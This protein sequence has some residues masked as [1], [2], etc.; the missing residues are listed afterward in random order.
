M[1]KRGWLVNDWLTAIPNTRTFWHDLLDWFP[2]LEDKT[3][4]YTDFSVL[5][6]RIESLPTRPDY[7]IR[8][9]TYFRKLNINIPTISLIQDVQENKTQQIDVIN[10]SNVVVFNTFY[11]YEKYKKYINDSIRVSICPLGVDFD[12]FKP[13]SEKNQ[14]VLPNSIL[15]IG[16]STIYPKGFDI[17]LK[18]IKNTNYN[19]C[20]ILKDDT[21]LDKIPLEDRQRVR[22]FNKISTADVRL[23]INS[24]ILCLC[25]SYEETQHLSGIECAACNIPIVA[26]PVGV[27]YDNRDSIEWGCLVN[28]DSKFIETIDF[29]IEHI[30]TFSP[31]KCFIKKYSTDICRH[32]WKCIIANLPITPS[33]NQSRISINMTDFYNII[34]TKLN[35]DIIK[36][37][38]DCGSMD[39]GD[40]KFFK[41]KYPDA[42]VYAIEGLKSNYDKFLASESGIIGINA[43]ISSYD[44]E[45]IFYEKNING[46]H[47]IYDRG[48]E[49][50]NVQYPV[51]CYRF[52]TI[53]K[54]Y[55]IDTID[56][57]KLDVEGASLCALQ[58]LGECLNN[59]KI[60]HIETETYPYFK[61]QKL[62]NECIKF[63]IDNNFVMLDI[64]FC[65]ITNDGYQSDSVWIHKSYF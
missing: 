16:S 10:S 65:K 17:L 47:S 33:N 22:I 44:G 55:S 59:V 50:G 38:V 64:T 25:T 27:Y 24:C 53:L 51:K 36:T 58:S 42:N 46:I 20:L 60:M 43:V 12:F 52:D 23:I 2:N 28:D 21:S 3:N 39:G 18:I 5:A 35:D 4:G 8:N 45:T 62:H 6:D 31:R 48:Q 26:R 15:F 32:N 14:S 41:N 63:L 56:I 37:I 11:V 13:L 61:G 1:I 7:I 54:R 34:K 49:Y 9:G 19:F 30:N 29:A 57:L 40:A